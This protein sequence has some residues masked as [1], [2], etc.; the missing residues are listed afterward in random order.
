MPWNPVSIR[1]F[2]PTLSMRPK[3]RSLLVE[4]LAISPHGRKLIDRNL[5]EFGKPPRQQWPTRGGHVFAGF[6]LPWLPEK[7]VGRENG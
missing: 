6:P 4:P 2:N 7:Q 1:S 3:R 5:T